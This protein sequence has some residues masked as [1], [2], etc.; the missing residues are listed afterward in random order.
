MS[1]SRGSG[2]SLSVQ[3]L[4]QKMARGY[5]I[6]FVAATFAQTPAV[7]QTSAADEAIE[8]IT[9]TGI[10]RSLDVAA[11]IKR[12]SGSVVDAITAEDIGRWPDTKRA[13]SLQ[14]IPGVSI[15]RV[16]GEGSKITVRGFGPEFNL[17]TLNGRT[18]PTATIGRPHT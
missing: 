8:E 9:V 7:A 16:N 12:E 13:E 11:D 17:I 14:R 18:L 15:D 5:G 1:R 4:L 6:L 3:A 2:V 10:R